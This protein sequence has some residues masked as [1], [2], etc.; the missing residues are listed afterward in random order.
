MPGGFTLGGGSLF[1]NGAGGGIPGEPATPR[2]VDNASGQGVSVD[3]F[4]NIAGDDPDPDVPDVPAHPRER[5]SQW[6]GH[7]PLAG[8]LRPLPL[9]SSLPAGYSYIKIEDRYGNPWWLIV[10]AVHLADFDGVVRT[11]PIYDLGEVVKIGVWGSQQ[12]HRTANFSQFQLARSEIN[13]G[14]QRDLSAAQSWAFARNEF[15]A[16]RRWV[17]SAE[18]IS[19]A[20]LCTLYGVGGGQVDEQV[21]T[22][23]GA[24]SWAAASD[25]PVSLVPRER[26]GELLRVPWDGYALSSIWPGAW[27]LRCCPYS[28]IAVID[29][30]DFIAVATMLTTGEINNRL[31]RLNDEIEDAV[32]SDIMN[33]AADIFLSA[34]TFNAVGVIRGIESLFHVTDNQNKFRDSLRGVADGVQVL[35]YRYAVALSVMGY[36]GLNKPKKPTGMQEGLAAPREGNAETSRPPAPAPE[37]ARSGGL[38]LAAAIL[39][40]I[41]G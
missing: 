40:L 11:D 3:V 17:L 27:H 10:G 15:H 25:L 41:F 32:G 33:G 14:R 2:T 34:I 19:S 39:W 7:G 1:L 26:A 9:R 13:Q 22:D 21:V 20:V 38:V 5:D 4:R 35:C 37:S 30:V 12:A 28:R 24:D 23:T 36:L 6:E 8:L 18:E 16:N 31:A 29:R